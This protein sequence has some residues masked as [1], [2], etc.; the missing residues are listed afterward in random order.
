MLPTKLVTHTETEWGLFWRK[1]LGG[2]VCDTSVETVSGDFEEHLHKLFLLF[3]LYQHLETSAL[4][5]IELVH[6]SR[7]P[8]LLNA[9]VSRGVSAQ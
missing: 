2:K 1:R 4:G 3:L 9:N 5:R 8:S 7:P 6:D